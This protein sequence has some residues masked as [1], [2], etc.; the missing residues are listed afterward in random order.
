ML[1]VY[2]EGKDQE[3]IF[4]FTYFY[5]K[6]WTNRPKKKKRKKK[7]NLWMGARR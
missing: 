2:I 6:L 3:Y 7:K 1:T 5:K 4:V